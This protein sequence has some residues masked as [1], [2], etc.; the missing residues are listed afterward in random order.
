MNSKAIYE[1]MRSVAVKG[2]TE[3]S[4]IMTKSKGEVF[5]DC[6]E[7]EAVAGENEVSIAAFNSS[8]TVQ[9]YMKTVKFQ[10]E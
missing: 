6:K 1:N 3:N 10:F 2:K 4:P 9:S 8:N 5:N 7:I